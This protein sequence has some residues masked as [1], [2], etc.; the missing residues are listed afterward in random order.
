MFRSLQQ[1]KQTIGVMTYL[2]LEKLIDQPSQHQSGD[3]LLNVCGWLLEHII[4]IKAI[5]SHAKEAFICANSC[6]QNGFCHNVCIGLCVI[7][8]FCD[9]LLII[10]PLSKQIKGGKSKKNVSLKIKYQVTK[11]FPWQIKTLTLLKASDLL[12]SNF[13]WA[14]K[15]VVA[16]AAARTPAIIIPTAK[17]VEPAVTTSIA[18]NSSMAFV[19]EFFIAKTKLD[20]SFQTHHSRNRSCYCHDYVECLGKL[21]PYT[22]T[23]VIILEAL[24]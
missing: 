6:T 21:Q 15:L 22:S 14:T 23:I 2:H 4:E 5:F 12:E 24:G 17:A 10:R 19:L 1:T 20:H 3:F 18:C 8:P 9:H 16:L 11:Q 7:L 13:L